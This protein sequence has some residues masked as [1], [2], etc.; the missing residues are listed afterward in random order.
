M[1]KPTGLQILYET[2]DLVAVLKPAGLASIPGRGETDSVLQQ[3]GRQLGLPTTGTADPRL[4]VVHRLDKDTSGVLLLA[5]ALPAQRHLSEQFQNNRVEKE[6]L[7]IVAGQPTGD[8]GQVE[9]RLAPHPA[10]RT[11]MA[12]V[13]R[14]G[15]PALTQWRVEQRF[16]WMALL[17]VFPRTGKTHQIRVHLAHA[18]MPLIVDPVYNPHGQPLMLSKIKRGYRPTAGEDERPLIA[19]LTLH[20]HRLSFTDLRGER[21]TVS[22]E[23]PKDFRAAVNM[24]SKWAR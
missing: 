12:V 21:Q 9:G 4:R 19:R 1:A 22:A 20:A 24:L 13:T 3:I 8:D 7:A 18:G 2:A 10:V 15:R 14:G 5:K 17:R 16:R 11:K 23:P 6:Y